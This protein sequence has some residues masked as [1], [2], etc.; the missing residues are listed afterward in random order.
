MKKMFLL[1]CIVVL[2]IFLV[3]CTDSTNVSEKNSTGG[4]DTD[5]TVKVVIFDNAL[6]PDILEKAKENLKNDGVNLEI[7]SVNNVILPN[8]SVSN[9]E[10]D[11]NWFQ[12][13]PYL[14]QAIEQKGFK[15]VPVAKTFEMV[16]GAFSKKY[17]KIDDLPENASIVI[18]ND[19]INIGKA[20]DLLASNGLIKLKEG[21]G[22]HA[23]QKDIIENKKNFK[24]TELDFSMLAKATD[25]SDLVVMYGS[26][27]LEAGFT[28]P[29]DDALISKYGDEWKIRLVA[30]PESQKREAV[31][32]VV[33][34][35]TSPEIIK[36]SKENLGASFIWE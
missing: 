8:E 1:I 23:T 25:D 4:D 19:P 17:S 33:K 27:A 26:K 10:A 12:H 15:L 31:Q 34:E 3:A 29:K 18:P 24:I 5:E 36:W 32:K 14:D 7:V 9:G 11:L 2:N 21:V 16:Y 6:F 35:L 30:S 28:K 13:Q 22:Y 20:L